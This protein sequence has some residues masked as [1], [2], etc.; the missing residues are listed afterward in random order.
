MMLEVQGWLVLAQQGERE[1]EAAD[2]S[3]EAE[4]GGEGS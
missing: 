1:D 2:C 4:G 3:S